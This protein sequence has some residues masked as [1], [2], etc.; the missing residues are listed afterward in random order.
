MRV[1]CPDRRRLAESK[2]GV[3]QN[4]PGS[5]SAFYPMQRKEAGRRRNTLAPLNHRGAW[6]VAIKGG[7][8]RDS[9]TNPPTGFGPQPF[10]AIRVQVPSGSF[11]VGRRGE[12]P[13][14]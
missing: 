4:A 14:P 8:F 11:N 9:G 13:G 5:I 1:A 10:G 2:L 12:L 7:E 3:Q 6:A